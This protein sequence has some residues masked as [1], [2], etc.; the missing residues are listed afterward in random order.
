MRVV[1]VLS[2]FLCVAA[3]ACD[4]AYMKTHIDLF[5]VFY[6][7]FMVLGCIGYIYYAIKTFRDRNK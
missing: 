5:K 4:I 3:V 1:F 2:M 7:C 6:P